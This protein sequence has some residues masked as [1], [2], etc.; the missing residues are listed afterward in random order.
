MT[1]SQTELAAGVRI[2][3][4]L[5]LGPVH[6]RTPDAPKLAAFYTD[7]LG[8]AVHD[9]SGSNIRLGAGGEDL[10]RLTQVADAKRYR[11]TTGLYHTAFLLP[12]RWALAHLLRRI[13][14]TRTPV[15]GLVDHHT[16]LAIYLPDSDGNGIELAWDYPK[17]QWPSFEDVIQLGNAPIDVDDLMAELARDPS[18]WNGLPGDTVVGHVHVHVAD[19]GPASAFYRDAVGFDRVFSDARV[20]AAFFRAGDYHHHLGANVWAGSGIPP[21]PDDAIGLIDYTVILPTADEVERVAQRVAHAGF[22]VE[23]GESVTLIDPFKI[24]A[25]LTTG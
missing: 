9:R 18:P 20:G 6:Y 15:Q 19:L 12:T 5:R 8:F 13:A 1:T 16:H 21:A 7:V 24:R 3:P 14:E 25:V 22:A 23:R 4:D 11:R 10:I 2:S 17:E